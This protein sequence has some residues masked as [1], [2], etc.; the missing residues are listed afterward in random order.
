M[1]ELPKAQDLREFRKV[2]PR[3]H[4]A[5][6]KLVEDLFGPEIKLITNNNHNSTHLIEGLF[7][8]ALDSGLRKPAVF[9]NAVDGDKKEL[10]PVAMLNRQSFLTEL[11]KRIGFKEEEKEGSMVYSS[12]KNFS[13]FQ[14][15]LAN[16]RK[17]DETQDKNLNSAGDYNLNIVAGAL[18]E[19]ASEMGS[20]HGF[21]IS[22]KDII[23]GRYG[24]DEFSLAVVGD[25][26]QEP[27]TIAMIQELIKNKIEER[28]GYFRDDKDKKTILRKKLLLK[29]GKV[30]VIKPPEENN[31]NSSDKKKIFYSFLRRGLVLS[32]EQLDFELQYINYK[33]QGENSVDN[34]LREV[35][36]DKENEYGSLTD[37]E[38]IT[39]LTNRHSELKVPFF[40]A[41]TKNGGDTNKRQSTLLHFV[42]N[43]LSDPLL[44]EIV[45]S[46]FDLPNHIRN[47]AFKNI[48]SFE[49]KL[50]EIDDNLSYVYGDQVIIKLWQSRLRKI[51]NPYIKEG[52]VKIGRFAGTIFIGEIGEGLPVEIRNELKNINEVTLDYKGNDI[53][54]SVG[55]TEL[56]TA[57]INYQSSGFSVRQK[58]GEVFNKPTEDWI[59][60]VFIRL[61]KNPDD[62]KEFQEIYKN[63]DPEFKY[64]GQNYFVLIAAK[65]FN[66]K[67]WEARSTT[68]LEVL[69]M[70][71][72]EHAEQ[73]DIVKGLFSQLK[74][75]LLEKYKDE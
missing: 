45:I 19:L 48:H 8:L 37:Q 73:I 20:V 36:F 66:G 14:M 47:D 12:E 31:P 75:E 44:G 26:S 64:K 5:E 52:K 51:L 46:R 34:Y 40:L 32:N 70:M 30:D 1:V 27:R 71:E 41:E 38:K 49:L 7:G 28:Q 22:P 69:N 10:E 55:Y 65:Y 63:L 24:G 39:Y 17:A 43:Y 33:D 29:G 58:T 13:I 25:I 35:L 56:D 59:K 53:A 57:N 74:P 6:K 2:T 42:E 9:L 23:V 21:N 72:G 18:N 50:K 54:H 4:Q 11:R 16:L 15:D 67:R 62:F 3:L 60:K 68:A 61:F